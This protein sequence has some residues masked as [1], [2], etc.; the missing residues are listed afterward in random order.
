[1]RIILDFDAVDNSISILPTGQ[2]GNRFSKHYSDQA[3]LFVTGGYRPQLMNRNQI[4]SNSKDPLI[5]K[6]KK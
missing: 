6:P 1:M 5:L 3:R 4:L 2:S